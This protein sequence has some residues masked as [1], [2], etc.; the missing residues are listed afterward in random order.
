VDLVEA[1]HA[2]V[3]H[4][5]AT[6][7]SAYRRNAFILDITVATASSLVAAVLRTVIIGHGVKIWTLGDDNMRWAALLMPLAWVL[8]LARSR[9]YAPRYIGAGPEEYRAVTRAVVVLLA[10]SAV[11]SYAFKLEVSRGY[12]AIALPMFL[13]FTLLGHYLMRVRLYHRR[14]GG[15]ML[16]ST[17]VVGRADSVAD[18]IRQIRQHPEVT[19][20]EVVGA[21][22][23]GMDASWVSLGTIEDVPILGAPEDAVLAVDRLQADVVAVASSPDFSGHPLRRLGWS[24]EQRG[25]DLLVSPGIIEVAGPRLSLR[26]AQGLSMLHVERPLTQGIIYRSKAVVDRVVGALLMV[27]ASPFLLLMAALIRFESKG[28]ALFKQ[29]RIGNEGQPFT[30]FKFRSMVQDAEALLPQLAATH[31]GNE[32]LFKMRE[33]PRVTRVGRFLRKSSLD[34]LPQLINVVRGDMSLV[35]PRPPL[36]D[37]VDNYEFDALRRLRVRPGMTGL[38]QVSGR[39]DLSWADSLRLDLWYVDNWS[40]ALDGQI[41]FRTAR[42]VLKGRGAY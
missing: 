24:L 31:D 3:A 33:D 32:V 27:L 38:W 4:G 7:Q 42:A 16:Q 20:L 23:S 5:L 35:G 21:C 39:S 11:L 41:L 1:G 25:V 19:G 6:W 9:A 34:E 12:I 13:G 2:R 22:V 18:M 30:M 36:G 10:G 8:C 15:E 28:P 17:L 29:V 14:A 40:W 26:P 37:E